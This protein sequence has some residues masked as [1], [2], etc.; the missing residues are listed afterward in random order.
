MITQGEASSLHAAEPRHL[1]LGKLMNRSLKCIMHFIESP[2]AD[3]IFSDIFIFQARF[4]VSERLCNQE[5]YLLD[6]L[7]TSEVNKMFGVTGVNW[8]N[9]GYESPE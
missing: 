7:P 2:F 6:P 4:V 8:Q 1:P 3:D 5:K 9:P